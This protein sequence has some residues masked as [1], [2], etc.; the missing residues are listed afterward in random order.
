MLT[1]PPTAADVRAALARHRIRLYVIAPLV[2]VHPSRL[3]LI[4]NERRPLPP[5]LAER[6]MRAIEEE[7]TR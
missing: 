6:L 2:G 5:D 7:A 1:T 4:V 3:S